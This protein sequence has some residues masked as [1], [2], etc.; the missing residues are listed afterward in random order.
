M[1]EAKTRSRRRPLPPVLASLCC[2][3]LL[4][5]CG[6]SKATATKSTGTATATT[7]GTST[8]E[9]TPSHVVSEHTVAA[10][11]GTVTASLNAAG[12]NPHVGVPWPIRFVVKGNDRPARA[13]E[14]GRAH[15]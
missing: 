7:S 15:V 14:I 3:L 10:T 8:G 6:G 9:A 12:H 11:S 5:A 1:L 2:T 13:E 4:A